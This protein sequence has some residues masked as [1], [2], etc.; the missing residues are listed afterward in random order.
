[1]LRAA[2]EIRLAE[3]LLVTCEIRILAPGTIERVEAG[4]AKRIYDNRLISAAFGP[5]I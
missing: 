3:T 2:V 1:V 4:K 5:G